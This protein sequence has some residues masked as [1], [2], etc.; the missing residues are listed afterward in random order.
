MI[1]V[2]G[3]SKSFR[4]TQGRKKQSVAA[5]NAIQMV[6]PDGKISALL[7]PNGAGKTTLLRIL[8]GL[9]NADD[10]M[11][12]IDGLQGKASRKE[13]AFLSDGCGLY[14]RLTAQENI[15]YFGELY[16]LNTQSI[17]KRINFLSPHLALDSL[18]ARKVGGFSQGE[19]MRVAIARALIHDPQTIVLD[20]PTNGLDLSSVRRLRAFLRFLVS[21]I[22]GGKCILFSTHVMHEVERLADHVMVIVKGQIK[23]TGTVA[24]ITAEMGERDFE[25]AF[26]KLAHGGVEG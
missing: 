24:S 20:E 17:E 2:N 14:S 23:T 12:T 5:L 4:A 16:G 3:I 8:A 7:G 13:L 22:G 9:E 10:G 6:V 1:E 15:T 25:E 21:P 11:A 26:V 18:L 19:R